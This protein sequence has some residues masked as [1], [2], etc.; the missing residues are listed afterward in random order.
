METLLKKLIAHLD[1]E[2]GFLVSYLRALQ[3]QKK[4]VSAGNV[5]EINSNSSQLIQLVRENKARSH[6]LQKYLNDLAEL[7]KISNGGITI[8]KLISRVNIHWAEK[9]A[10]QKQ[11]LADIIQQIKHELETNK[12][13]LNYALNFTHSIIQMNDKALKSDIVYSKNGCKQKRTDQIKFLDH[14]F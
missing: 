7:F 14:K 4:Y 6:T 12:Y 13:L 3:D 8:S 11:K 1:Y 2:Y 5:N 9:L 10:Q